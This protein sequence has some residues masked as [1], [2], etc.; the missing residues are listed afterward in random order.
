MKDMFS[1]ISWNGFITAVGVLLFIY[2][3]VVLFLYY[4]RD[5]LRLVKEGLKRPE[6]R[7]KDVLNE[8]K[9][10]FSKSERDPPDLSNVHELMD[11]L[12]TLF[13]SAA[14]RKFPK[15]ELLM[16][17]QSKLQGYPQLKDSFMRSSINYH[18]A[19]ESQVQCGF[20]MD[21]S[22]LAKLW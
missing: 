20:T 6:P 10:E 16:A 19:Q 9:P 21:E 13:A 4:R 8:F 17:L 15:E 5:I 7:D 12:N 2:Y 22:E 1:K 3:A 18:I 11:E 14:E